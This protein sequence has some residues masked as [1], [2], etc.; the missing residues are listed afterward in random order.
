MSKGNLSRQWRRSGF[1][2]LTLNIFHTFY[3]FYCSFSA[4][5]F[6]V[7]LFC[8]S[9]PFLNNVLKIKQCHVLSAS[10]TQFTSFCSFPSLSTLEST[11]FLGQYFLGGRK[12]E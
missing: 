12:V 5:K 4:G 2:V 7:L 3:C 6:A 10:L 9:G 11:I 1:F 8:I